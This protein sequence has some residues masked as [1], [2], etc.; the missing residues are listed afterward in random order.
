MSQ[1]SQLVEQTLKQF[2]QCS[3]KQLQRFC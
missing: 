3:L 2:K 1:L